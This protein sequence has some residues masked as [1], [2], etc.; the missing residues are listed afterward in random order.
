MRFRLLPRA[1]YPLHGALEAV[2]R[3][4]G[5]RERREVAHVALEAARERLDD[6]GLARAR[7]HVGLVKDGQRERRRPAQHLLRLADA[8][9]AVVGGVATPKHHESLKENDCDYIFPT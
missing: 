2:V 9:Q 6:G 7:H 4:L 5:V 1:W 8:R 3:H